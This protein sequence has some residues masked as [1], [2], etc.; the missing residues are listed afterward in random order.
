MNVIARHVL[1]GLTALVTAAAIAAPLPAAAGTGHVVHPGDSIQAAVDAAAP[2]DT[3]VV[4]RGVYRESVAIQKD[5]ITLRGDGRVTIKPP[6]D[7]SGLCNQP[8]EMIGICILPADINFDDSS[9]G[10]RVRDVTIS[11]LRVVGFEGDGV[12]AFGSEN[13]RLSRVTAVRNSGYGMARFDG[14]G[15]WIKH[16]SATGSEEAGIYVGDS[17]EANALVSHNR[18]WNNGIGVFV[19]HVHF[20][21]VRD[22]WVQHNCIGIFLLNDGQPEGSGDT[23]VTRNDVRNNSKFCPGDEEEGIPETSG[24][25]IVL[26]GSVNNVVRR[27]DVS[28]NHGN[29]FVSGGIVLLT[30]PFGAVPVGSTGN[31]VARN[32]LERNSPAD[33]VQD[34]GST[35]NTFRRNSC[36]TSIP[37]GLC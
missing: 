8:G 11:H 32:R 3:I 21:S 35:G 31:L 16:S 9:Y 7:G 12:F 37:D 20:A 24:G 30:S 17:P 27:N 22:N 1:V 4:K 26:L 23:T 19:R 25:G 2:G 28:G 29:T 5:G 10:T 36:D 13:L 14:I 33:L 15:G 34:A 6:T 18:S